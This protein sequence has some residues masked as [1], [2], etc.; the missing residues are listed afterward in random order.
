M[1]QKT[2]DELNNQIQNATHIEDFL[3]SNKDELLN[4]N[5]S[6][7]LN[8]LLHQKGL[9]KSDVVRLSNLNRVYVHQIFTGERNP[10]RNKL[11][12][13][14]FGLKLTVKETTTLLKI[15]GNRELYP[16][17]KRDAYIIF[18]LHQQMSLINTNILL[19]DKGFQIIE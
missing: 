18:A 11:I 14:S 13:L 8:M 15:S 16:R 4:V 9:T 1:Q 7:H 12:A 5:L 19:F 10:S 3:S 2:T 17:D 6:Q